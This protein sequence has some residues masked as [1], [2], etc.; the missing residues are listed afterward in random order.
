MSET[1]KEIGKDYIY[2]LFVD[3]VD[4]KTKYEILSGGLDGP[5]FSY[6]IHVL[7]EDLDDQ[8]KKEIL[9]NG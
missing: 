8:T 1:G 4:D 9:L 7:P 6:G 5:K 2:N 3:D